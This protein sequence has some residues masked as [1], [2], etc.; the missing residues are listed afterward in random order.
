MLHGT[1]TMSYS[2]SALS[3]MVQNLDKPVIFTG[4]QIPIGVP[5]TDGKENLITSVEIA[6]AK[7]SDGKP[8]VPEVCVYFEN[9]LFRGNR[10]SKYS[11]DHFNAFRSYNYPPLAEAGIDIKYNLP[12]IRKMDAF[13]PSFDITTELSPYVAVLKLYPGISRTIVRG[14]LANP[15]VKGV[16]METFGS[17]NAPMYEWFLDEIREAIKRDVIILNT[18]QCSVG[19][20]NMEIY[21]TGKALKSIGVVSGGDMTVEA[22]ITKMMYLLGK[23]LDKEQLIHQLSA[24]IRGEMTHPGI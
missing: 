2:A 5:R 20:V 24:P 16:V 8:L 11:A 10:T 6:A 19:T 13:L 1:D 7:G 22:A 14:I 3:F 18:T 17:G 12:Y 4:S 9:H 15:E 21:D 23:N